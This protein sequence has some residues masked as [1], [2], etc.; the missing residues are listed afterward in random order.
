MAYKGAKI[1]SLIITILIL[2]Q[3]FVGS[4]IHKMIGIETIQ[5]LQFFYFV[6]I[7]IEQNQTTILN[8]MNVFKYTAYGG[9]SNY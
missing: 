9:Y 5:I 8:S 3:F 6:R 2:L 1:S 4:Y 7:I